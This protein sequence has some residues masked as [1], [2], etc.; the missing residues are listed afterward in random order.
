M[1]EVLL[2][3]FVYLLTAVWVVW[4]LVVVGLVGHGVLRVIVR[5]SGGR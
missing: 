1:G 2:R 3:L 5:L 4:T